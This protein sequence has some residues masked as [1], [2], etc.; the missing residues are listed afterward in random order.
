MFCCVPFSGMNYL[1]FFIHLDLHNNAFQWDAY[2]PRIDH[3]PVFSVL[4]VGVV[5]LGWGRGGGGGGQTVPLA[6]PPHPQIVG[7]MTDA[8]EKITFTPYYVCGR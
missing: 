7:R 6:R 8:C 1:L 5:F 3:I 4:E 2:R